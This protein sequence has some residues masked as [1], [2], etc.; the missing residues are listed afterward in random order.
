MMNMAQYLS[1][2]AHRRASRRVE[3]TA[4][5]VERGSVERQVRGGV[6]TSKKSLDGRFGALSVDGDLVSQVAACVQRG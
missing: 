6:G 4:R 5:A 3:L 2:V 1:S